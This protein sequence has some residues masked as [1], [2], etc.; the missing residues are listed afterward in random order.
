MDKNQIKEAS[1][2]VGSEGQPSAQNIDMHEEETIQN[3]L[4]EYYKSYYRDTLSINNWERHYHDVR[5]NEEEQRVRLFEKLEKLKM[6][7]HNQKVLIVGAGTGAELFCLKKYFGC[8]V[9][10]IEPYDKAIEILQKKAPAYGLAPEHIKQAYS[11]ELPYKD[12]T[13]DRVISFS[14]VEHVNN[15]PKTLDEMIR[16]VKDDGMVYIHTPNYVFPYEGHYKVIAPT[17]L[18]KTLTKIW[19]SMLGK[20]SGFVDTLQF[21]TTKSIDRVLKSYEN[22]YYLRL[23]ENYPP[24]KKQIRKIAY[25]FW[26]IFDFFRRKL[27][28]QAHQEIIIHKIGR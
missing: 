23:G 19:V 16:V 4:D 25:L 9:H 11:E 17:F 14:V 13:F 8:D 12:N 15:V 24:K 26:Y 27:N 20:K 18:G 3:L 2:M 1:E 28:I 10:G 7:M 22:I 5:T 21:V 6:P